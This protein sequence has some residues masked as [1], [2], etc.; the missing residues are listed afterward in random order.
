MFQTELIRILQ[1]LESGFMTGFLQAVSFLG[2]GDT[3]PFLLLG[4]MFGFHLRAG[5][6]LFQSWIWA[7]TANGV[8]KAHLRLPRP[9]HVDGMVRTFG[10]P[11]AA[12]PPMVPQTTSGFFSIPSA[13][14][15]SSAGFAFPSGHCAGTAAWAGALF[16]LIRRPMARV[17][18]VVWMLLMAISRLYLGRHFPADVLA[19]TLIGLAAALLVVSTTGRSIT[20]KWWLEHPFS[21]FRPGWRRPLV[22]VA[23]LGGPLIILL[24]PKAYASAAAR[25]LGLN[26]GF[27]WVW[28]RGLPQEG[29]SFRQR[30]ARTCLGIMVYALVFYTPDLLSGGSGTTIGVDILRHFLAPFAALAAGIPL[31]IRFGVWSR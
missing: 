26:L 17:L 2:D 25:L 7:V 4:I 5:F 3:L 8:L 16:A 13:V 18:L 14:S 10:I 24:I 31:A 19:G 28:W 15:S 22:L 30:L 27:L 29:G 23:A 11:A 21:G 12:I 1:T 6:I 20:L 9:F